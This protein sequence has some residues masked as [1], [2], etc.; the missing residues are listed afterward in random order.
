MI[1]YSPTDPG[2]TERLHIRISRTADVDGLVALW[3]NPDA[4]RHTG[5]PRDGDFIAKEFGLYVENPAH[6]ARTEHEWWWSVIERSS[7]E[8]A[9]QCGLIEK[10]VEGQTEM[11]LVYFFLPAFWGKGYATEAAGRVAAHAFED[12]GFDSVVS[13]IDP[14]N[15]ASAGVA[16]KL[17]MRLDRDILRSDGVTR[18]VFRLDRATDAGE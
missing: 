9:G 5:G 10:E 7:G 11:E 14:R 18:Q 16:R 15:A 12:I 17:G 13:I 8:F 6:F 1:S 2:D 4:M 3:T